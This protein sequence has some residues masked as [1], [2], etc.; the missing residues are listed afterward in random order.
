MEFPITAPTLRLSR[1]QYRETPGIPIPFLL[2]KDGLKHMLVSLPDQSLFLK[3]S[4]GTE[5]PSLMHWLSGEST[6]TKIAS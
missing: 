2:S 1:Q 5:H 6:L 4:I 3:T